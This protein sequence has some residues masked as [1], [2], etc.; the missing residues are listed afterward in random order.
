MENA[1]PELL[2]RVEP[3][4][5]P[6]CFGCVQLLRQL[7]RQ[8]RGSGAGV[9]H[10]DTLEDITGKQ[11]VN[12]VEHHIGTRVSNVTYKDMSFVESYVGQPGSKQSKNVIL[13]IKYASVTA[14][15]GSAWLLQQV[16]VPE[17]AAPKR[18]HSEVL[19]TLLDE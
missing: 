13:S 10:C 4:E 3:K 5:N 11:I 7:R 18:T 9:Y 19:K 1:I 6:R 16:E 8:V 17:L 15:K 2:N 14:W 12:M